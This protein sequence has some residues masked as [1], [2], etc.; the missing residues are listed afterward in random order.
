M[1]LK[2]HLERRRPKSESLPLP[3]I[4]F[5][6]IYVASRC[7]AYASHSIVG[8]K[9]VDIEGNAKPTRDLNHSCEMPVEEKSKRE[10]P[11]ATIAAIFEEQLGRTVRVSKVRSAMREIFRDTARATEL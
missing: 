5:D 9:E 2:A 1:L 3:K 10:V 8:H 6:T 7:V 4:G 11:I